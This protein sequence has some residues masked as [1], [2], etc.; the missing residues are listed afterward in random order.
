M[1]QNQNSMEQE[2]SLL[3]EA[4]KAKLDTLQVQ[5]NKAKR[6]IVQS[7]AKD[8]EG[9]VP[10]DSVCIEIV[11]QLSGRVSSRF[12][13][14][15]LDEKHKQKH[16][17]EN[18]KKQKN[19]KKSLAAVAPLKQEA[20]NKELVI[21]IYDNVATHSEKSIALN[22]ETALSNNQPDDSRKDRK[23]EVFVSHIPLSFKHL[24]KDMDAVFQIT[25]GVGNIFFK[26]SVDLGTHMVKIEF[27][28]NT[29][30][31]NVTMASTGEG[32]LNQAK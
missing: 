2:I 25:K 15:C 8:L 22:G 1:E 9:K 14:E 12:I 30:Q 11:T 16:R 28:G 20:E 27:C 4:A 32:I 7:L 26:V 10:Q 24:W 5:T 3:F 13:C 29:Q 18:A 19:H 6:E 17:V 23:K 31:K 21:D